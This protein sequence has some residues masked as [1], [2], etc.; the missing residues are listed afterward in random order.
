MLVA[1]AVTGEI[2]MA[3]RF[4]SE[5]LTE[6]LQGYGEVGASHARTLPIAVFGVNPIGSKAIIDRC[7][8][9]RSA[10]PSR[11]VATIDVSRIS[12]NPQGWMRVGRYA[13]LGNV[14][15]RSPAE[16]SIV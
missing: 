13:N 15:T 2:G 10:V 16:R 5:T 1:D 9:Q 14:A 11:N 7:S 8:L 12:G 4:V 3:G 6:R